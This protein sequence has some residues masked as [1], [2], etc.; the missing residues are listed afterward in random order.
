MVEDFEDEAPDSARRAW[1]AGLEGL[2]AELVETWSLAAVGRPLQPGGASAWVAPVH[3]TDGRDAVLKVGWTHDE[4]LH[5]ADGLRFWAGDGTVRLYAS[6]AEGATTAL[7]LERCR[8]GTPLGEAEQP[9]RQDVVVSDVLRIS[10]RE[11]PGDMLFRPLTEMCDAWASEF[12]DDAAEATI[13]PIPESSAP[14]WN[15]CAAFLG[16]RNERRAVYRPARG[17]FLAAEREPWLVIDPK[18]YV[19]D[20]A[21]D[22]VQYMLNN[23]GR[24]MTDSDGFIG[25]IAI[26]PVSIESA[27][28]S[29]YSRG[30]CRSRCARVRCARLPRSWRQSPDV[31]EDDVGD[32]LDGHG[33]DD[34]KRRGLPQQ[35]LDRLQIVERLSDFG[36]ILPVRV[37]CSRG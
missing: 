25:G 4:A 10:W 6:R 37:G 28:P 33:G 36:R 29:G 1:L 17:K 21:Y 32:L 34:L 2:V 20:P 13:S 19:G 31:R 24:L 3:T 12:E 30:A 9:E 5:E 23:P 8:P 15:C 27:W 16:R 7:L 11:P 22:P 14:E 35:W 26:W 18:P